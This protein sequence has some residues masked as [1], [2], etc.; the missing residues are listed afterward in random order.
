[1]TVVSTDVGDF[2]DDDFLTVVSKKSTMMM[3]AVASVI[4]MRSCWSD[5]PSTRPKNL[6]MGTSSL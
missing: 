2:P 5:Q 6:T 4:L 1:M 3:K